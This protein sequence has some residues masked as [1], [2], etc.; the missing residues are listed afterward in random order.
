MSS[1]RFEG[2]RDRKNVGQRDPF[3]RQCSH[4]YIVSLVLSLIPTYHPTFVFQTRM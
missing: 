1:S 3:P 2:S 4:E